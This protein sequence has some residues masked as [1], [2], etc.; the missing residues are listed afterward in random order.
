MRLFTLLPV[1]AVAVCALGLFL[2]QEADDAA[3]TAPQAESKQTTAANSAGSRTAGATQQALP[4]PPTPPE[5]L[6]AA[7]G[8]L[9]WRTAGRSP[10]SP[11]LPVASVKSPLLPTR[12]PPVPDAAPFLSWQ[13]QL[14]PLPDQPAK[15]VV[16]PVVAAPT[17]GPVLAVP[18][19]PQPL[20]EPLPELAIASPLPDP[21]AIASLSAAS[22]PSPTETAT[23]A[24]VESSVASVDPAA[25]APMPVSEQGSNS[26]AAVPSG[27]DSALGAIA[28]NADPAAASS[29]QT[30]AGADAPQPTGGGRF[31]TLTDVSPVRDGF[32]RP[33]REIPAPL[34]L[35][36][37][38]ERAAIAG[39][40]LGNPRQNAPANA[41]GNSAGNSAENAIENVAGMPAQPVLV[42]AAT[43]TTEAQDVPS[44]IAAPPVQPVQPVQLVQAMPASPMPT[45]G[46]TGIDET[47]T[48][49]PGDAV[50]I[51]FFNVP[52]Y[53]GQY[54]VLVDGSVN[55][56]VVGG[57]PVA[58]MTLRDASLAIAARYRGELRHPRVTLNL[59]RS[60]PLR[61][62]IAGEVRQPGLYTLPL[63]ENAQ[64]PTVAQALQTAGGVTQAANLR[65]VELRRLQRGGQTQVLR[66]NLWEL[67]TNGDV[68]QNLALRDG[69]TL[70][71]PETAA[72]N[73]TEG[74]QLADSNL[75][76]DSSRPIDVALVGEV[77]RPGSYKVGGGTSGGRPTLT[78]AIQ[79][80]G[81]ITLTANIREIQV[82]RT[83]R[84]G[85]AQMINIDFTQLL[86]AGDLNQDILLQQG[87]VVT[88]PTAAQLTPEEMARS[89]AANVA[90]A[91]V[92]VNVVGEVNNP[93]TIQVPPNT[94][95][96]QAVLSAGGFNR[97][98]R[99]S[100][101][102]LLRLNPNGSITRRTIRVDLDRGIDNENNPLVVNGD[103][104]VV[105]RS[106]I[107]SFSDGLDTFLNPFFRLLG[108]IQ[109]LF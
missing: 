37:L 102:Q 85:N 22:L 28:P 12:L 39:A 59:L 104:I 11:P 95:L 83:T 18:P 98:A 65:Q 99:R 78:Q 10:T 67:I 74:V 80:A 34:S 89:A 91:A 82:R 29:Q 79:Q 77:A 70:V 103:V 64:F 40:P 97:R 32:V 47:Y 20:V 60:R 19:A 58:G 92:R 21:A 43:S 57:V 7:R 71:I 93:G 105:G 46:S 106:G 86:Q 45:A 14:T 61:V 42:A 9:D 8:L 101:V 94:T 15:S 108:P 38:P 52:E 54:Q 107:A 41:T 88:I 68:S 16:A 27:A 87:D 81:G 49:G 75:A 4:P 33:I 62:A 109:L 53:S 36:P 26:V 51:N 44:G 50:A 73:P 30:V 66:L 35:L 96:N 84:R 48:L 13:Q 76:A 69:D 5:A 17:V 31:A 63:N 2:T 55:L 25:I 1:S 3:E 24:A 23:Q 90:P 100:S 72:L 6:P 56:P